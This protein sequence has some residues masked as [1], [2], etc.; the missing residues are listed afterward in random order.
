[1]NCSIKPPLPKHVKISPSLICNLHC[2]LCPSGLRGM[3]YSS[4]LM[5]LKTFSIIL[6]KLPSSIKNVSLYNLG[7]P[8]LNP[9]LLF[10]IKKLKEKD[11]K[12][13][14]HT[15]FSFH[16][17]KNFF[18][19]LVMSG[20][21]TLI[22]SLDGASQKTYSH[23]RKGGDFNLVIEN[24][25]Q[26]QKL[27]QQK[28]NGSL[29]VIWKF[30]INKYTEHE[31]E[32]AKNLAESLGICFI[33]NLMGLGDDLV[34][35]QIPTSFD[36][37]KKTWLPNNEKHIKP[38]YKNNE[39]TPYLFNQICS[40]LFLNPVIKP[41]GKITCCCWITNKKNVFGDLMKDSFEDIW[42]NDIYR[43]SRS[44]FIENTD[45]ELIIPYPTICE[46]CKNFRKKTK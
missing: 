28:N 29:K 9:N 36:E 12:V 3:N 19:K 44:L 37:R 20:L 8:F 18:E 24:L 25:R 43:Y 30:L 26:I 22:I 42:Y 35:Y 5:T 32:K 46:N 6:N 40:E 1:M 45:N 13:E 41:D 21:D 31:I 34:D 38:C 10:M 15:N 7:E 17:K 11:Y 23:Y 39:P 27:N 4:K 16:K 33:T 2:P 14:I